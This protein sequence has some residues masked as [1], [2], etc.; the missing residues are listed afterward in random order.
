[1]KTGYDMTAKTLSA[2]DHCDIQNLYAAYNLCSDQGDAEGYV[3][4]FTSDGELELQPSGFRVAGRAAL[5]EHKLRDVSQ[6]G[7]RYRRHWNS[8]IHLAAQ[9]DG[10][11]RGSCY[12]LA[13]N[14][15]AGE[16]PQIADCGVYQ[17][18]IVRTGEG[19]AFARRLLTMDASTWRSR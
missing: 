11:V 12:L 3:G 16:L 19:W 18:L 7:T 8:G 13:F 5:L 1:M 6:R 10:T 14:G 4:C 15:E 9:A 17:D 2:Q